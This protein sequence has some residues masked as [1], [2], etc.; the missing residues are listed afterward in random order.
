MKIINEDFIKK[1]GSFITKKYFSLAL[2]FTTAL[3][4]LV[5]LIESIVFLFGDPSTI[6]IMKKS[7]SEILNGAQILLIYSS[8]S[9]FVG[10]IIEMRS[11]FKNIEFE[12]IKK[13]LNLKHASDSIEESIKKAISRNIEEP[14]PIK[15]YGIKHSQALGL[16]ERVLTNVIVDEKRHRKVNLY[17]Y[18]SDTEYLENLKS[19]RR[20]NI[21]LS[22]MID[23][24]IKKI[25]DNIRN[26]NEWKDDEDHNHNSYLS[27]HYIKHFDL[28]QFWVIQIDCKNTFWGYFTWSEESEKDI[29]KGSLNNCFL[30][31]GNKELDGFSD[32]IDNN[33]KRLDKWHERASSTIS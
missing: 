13:F 22:A 7:L 18:S 23:S 15:I 14:L 32:W 25:N 4:I 27:V 3:L 1:I 29:F 2:A 9:L 21:K 26:L 28:P 24:F 11:S 20:G 31:E 33:F 5:K 10:L 6:M 12:R 30:F 8:V 19:L 16:I 17:L